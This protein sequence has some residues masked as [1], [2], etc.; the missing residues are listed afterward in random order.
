MASSKELTPSTSRKALVTSAVA[1]GLLANPIFRTFVAGAGFFADSYDLFA[2][3]GVGNILKSLGP[4]N[5]VTQTYVDWTGTQNSLTSYATF[6]CPQKSSVCAPNHYVNITDVNGVPIGGQWVP[7][8]ASQYDPEMMPLYQTQTTFLKNGL[9]NAASFGNVFGQVFF[10]VM[11]D[12]MGRRINFI[13]TSSLIIFG[14][15]G[16]ATAS[17]GY[18]VAGF[19]APNGLW[20][21]TNA[22]PAGSWNDVYG[23]LF[24]WRGIL[25]FGVGGEYPLAATITSE[26]STMATRGRAVLTIFSMQGA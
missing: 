4:A 22:L 13:I 9:N 20:A 17:A 18:A 21:N 25:G 26:A 23:Q 14:C 11:G 24:V 2:T 3:D 10:G 7:N 1:V 8:P 12:L 19:M 16:A 15:L 6:L 5:K